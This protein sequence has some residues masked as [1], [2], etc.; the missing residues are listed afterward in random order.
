MFTDEELEAAVL[1]Y[2]TTD[3][4][5]PRSSAGVRDI[6]ATKTQVY[7]IVSAAFLLRPNA[8]FSV[9]WLASNKL[10]AL[11][12]EQIEDLDAI[13]AAA[14]RVAKVSTPVEST[15]ELYNAEAALVTLTGAFL[16]RRSGVANGIG[17]AVQ[18]FAASVERFVRGELTKNVVADG[19]V[20]KTPEQLRVEVADRWGTARARHREIVER[21]DRLVNALENF[22]S[23][24]LPDTVV[25]SLLVRIQERLTELT[26]QMSATTAPRD[27]RNALLELSAMRTLLSQAAQFKHPTIN[28]APLT[29]DATR[30]YLVRST[31]LPSSILG[32]VS[33]PFNYRPG[34]RLSYRVGGVD[35]ELV[36]PGSSIAEL[37]SEPM[38]PFV[39]P[40]LPAIVSLGFLE[41]TLMTPAEAW[42]T[43]ED[44]A[45]ALNELADEVEVTWDEG[46]AQLVLQ[47]QSAGD[48]AFL[49]VRAST[50]EEQAFA[51]W[52]VGATGLRRATG[53]PVGAD[54]VA[55]AMAVDGRLRTEVIRSAVSTAPVVVGDDQASLVYRVYEGEGLVAD[56]STTVRAPVDLEA[57]GVQ[58]YTLIV[59]VDPAAPPLLILSVSGS[60][61]ELDEPLEAG[62]YRY[63]VAPNGVAGRRVVVE[64][65]TGPQYY[66]AL[67][68]NAGTISLD[69]QLLESAGTTV[70]AHFF[71][72]YIMV[73]AQEPGVTLEF[74]ESEGTSALGFSLGVRRSSSAAFDTGIDL[75]ARNVVPGDL[76]VLQSASQSTYDVTAV[77]GTM[78]QFAPNTTFSEQAYRYSIL[79]GVVSRYLQFRKD[80]GAVAIDPSFKDEARL[81]HTMA[82]L[83]RGARYSNELSTTINQYGARLLELQFLCANY[84][85][86]RDATVEQAVRLMVEQGFDRA[87]DLFLDLRLSEFFALDADAVSYKTWV[88]RNAQLVAQ[89]VLPTPKGT[90]DPTQGIQTYGVQRRSSG[91]P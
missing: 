12:E 32:S 62:T 82:R 89:T 22:A 19:S 29:G 44:A 26:A 4:E 3:V 46:A 86:Q 11:V 20:V 43:G 7:E 56:G 75:T 78:V 18:R 53:V 6:V 54:A 16:S 48:G 68:V 70:R 14:P 34:A 63:Y 59:P 66:E 77:Q 85:V 31:G 1:H 49:E 45:A 39:P 58:A 30:G 61:L 91:E 60:T 90:A 40:T 37:R 52:L 81:D 13:A 88:L 71:D 10:R 84:L 80:L 74:L 41:G 64:S 25:G 55:K 76:L 2:L 8:L 57:L 87:A 69:R 67:A 50:L 24:R 9:C 36:L 28:R 65:V 27:S 51:E 5:T 23:V 47:T 72:G 73:T 42:A 15:T 21:V 33:G 38:S 79:D 83:S 35:A 17:P